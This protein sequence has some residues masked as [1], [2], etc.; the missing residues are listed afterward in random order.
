MGNRGNARTLP[1]G[2]RGPYTGARMPAISRQGR[3]AYSQY[4]I[5]T[6]IWK[7]DFSN[8]GPASRLVTS[9][10][11]DH[12][13]RYSP[14]GKRIAFDS[15][16]SGTHEIWTCASDG[17][18]AVQL[19]SFEGPNVST[20]FWS[21]DGAWIGF[22][23]IGPDVSLYTVASGGGSPKR[24]RSGVTGAAWSHDGEWIYFRVESAGEIWKMRPDGSGA[25]VLLKR[26]VFVA[27]AP[28]GRFLYFTRS[29]GFPVMN[30]WK[31]PIGGGSEIKV[32]DR[33]FGSNYDI[34]NNGRDC[35]HR[36][37]VRAHPSFLDFATGKVRSIAR[38]SGTPEVGFSVSP[39]GSSLLYVQFEEHGGSDL[40]LAERDPASRAPASMFGRCSGAAGPNGASPRG[41]EAEQGSTF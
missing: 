40:M 28:D 25:S 15:D 27:E 38:T 12:L 13:P 35:L 18:G 24:L 39:D 30:L 31:V 23:V 16:C 32:L 21:P 22:T 33:V 29:G 37:Q 34:T 14:D 9:T 4:I 17:A 6:D 10:R 5:D 3:I 2:S 19:T 1:S 26:A 8:R 36:R 20:P 41:D 11:I 7:L